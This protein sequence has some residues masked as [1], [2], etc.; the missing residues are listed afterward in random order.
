MPGASRILEAAGAFHAAHEQRFAHADADA[1]VEAVNVRAVA[2]VPSET[3]IP[4]PA[5]GSGAAPVARTPVV[6]DGVEHDTA[7]YRRADF[8]PDDVVVGPAIVVQLDTTTLVE[9]GWSARADAQGNLILE[10]T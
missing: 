3:P 5:P 6:V 10:R 1:S 9:P 8:R 7:V 4:V 2:R